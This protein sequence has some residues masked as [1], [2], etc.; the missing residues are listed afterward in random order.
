MIPWSQRLSFNFIFFFYLEIYDAK[1]WSK[2]RAERKESLWL[3]SLRISLSCWLSTWQLSKTSFS[4]DQ[5]HPQRYLIHPII[6]LVEQFK[7]Y[8]PTRKDGQKLMAWKWGSQWSW[9]DA[10]FSR[11]SAFC[12]N[13]ASQNSQERIKESLWDQGKDLMDLTEENW[14]LKWGISR[15]T[16]N[17]P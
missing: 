8:S 13:Y 3:T 5:S 9:P 11:L 6:W 7:I 12:A 17:S 14:N 15:W 10:F 4:F 2:R 16:P 1:R